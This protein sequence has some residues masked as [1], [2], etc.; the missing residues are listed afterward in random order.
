VTWLLL[1]LCGLEVATTADDS[2]LQEEPLELALTLQQHVLQAAEALSLQLPT[3][4]IT[5]SLPPPMSFLG[6]SKPPPTHLPPPPLT[7]RVFPVNADDVQV[8]CVV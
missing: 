8:L 4:I 5:S 2:G 3:A 6:D 7:N 1:Q